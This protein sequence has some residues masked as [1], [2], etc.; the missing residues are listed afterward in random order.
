MRVTFPEYRRDMDHDVGAQFISVGLYAVPG[1]S[2]INHEVAGSREWATVVSNW[3]DETGAPVTG[4]TVTLDSPLE[5]DGVWPRNLTEIG[6]PIYEWSFGDLAQGAWESVGVCYVSPN[7]LFPVTFT[8]GF[9]ASC[10]VDKTEFLQSEGTQTQTVTITLTP[11]QAPVQVW[12][13]AVHADDEYKAPDE[14]D[15]IDAVINPPTSGD[16][17]RF[18]PDGHTLFMY[19]AELGLDTTY[20][21]Y[22]TIEVTPKVPQVEFIP[23]VEV[24]LGESLASGTA[25][26]NS[27]SCPPDVGASEVGTWTVS[28][29]GNYVWHWEEWLGRAVEWQSCYREIVDIPQATGELITDLE[30]IVLNNPDTPLADKV[31][32]ALAKAETALDEL[33]KTPPDNQAAVGNIEGAVGDLEA[34]VSDGLLDPV[35]GTQL[36]DEF[37][38]I[39][40]QLAVDALDQAIASG[41][42]PGPINEAQQALAEGDVL[43]SLGAF[44]NAVNKYKDALAKAESAISQPPAPSTGVKW[45]ILGPILAVVIFLTIFLSIRLRRRRACQNLRGGGGSTF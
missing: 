31:E 28:A 40:R 37:A 25:E 41:G 29:E 5:F 1:E 11:R 16:G 34:A 38:A 3:D 44:K 42:D 19:P 8:P 23:Y 4:L 39:A 17:F 2:F 9:D 43:R 35:Q 12:C 30:D 10:S 24:Y 21:Y 13:I 20:T 15:L 33:T 32:D 14:Y 18:D 7:P 36:M 26:G 27:V 6:P 22:V 45:P